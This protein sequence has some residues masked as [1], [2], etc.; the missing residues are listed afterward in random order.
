MNRVFV[1]LLMLASFPLQ[2]QL[3]FVDSSLIS[4]VHDTRVMY[5]KER[6]NQ[7]AV[8]NGLQHY[9]YSATIEGIAYY[10]TDE[11]KKGY[12][13][14][15][16]ILY[17]DIFMKYD[18]VAD[19]LIVTPNYDG[20]LFIALYSPRVKEFSFGGR[21][22]VRLTKK[23]TDGA[24]TE[25]FYQELSK[26]KVIAYQR[27][28]KFIEEKVDVTGISRW[29]EEKT[30]YF[31]LREGKYK[32]IRNKNDLTNLLKEHRRE[33]SQA[34]SRLN[35]NYRKNVQQNIIAATEAYNQSN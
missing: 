34:I 15:S 22:F 4:K 35:L 18:V 32:M 19:Q 2:A 9:P 28:Q 29:F 26:G 6:G 30:R 3:N 33:V 14:F 20:G 21:K 13:V 24:L 16:D 5:D 10:P 27:T 8:F 23:M 17:E 12:V 25:G 1:A 11:W 7:L 31:M